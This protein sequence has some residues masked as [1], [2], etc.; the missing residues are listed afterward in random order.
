[1]D[2]I[3]G[4]PGVGPKSAVALLNHFADLDT[5]FERVDELSFGQMLRRRFLLTV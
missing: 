4:I 3:P 2:N 1:V 5:I